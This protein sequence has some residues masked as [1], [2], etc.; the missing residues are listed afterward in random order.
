VT[1][2]ADDA[3]DIEARQARHLNIQYQDVRLM[4]F[5]GAQCFDTIFRFGAYQEIRPEPCERFREF[6]AQQRLVLGD[7]GPVL[8]LHGFSLAIHEPHAK[9]AVGKIDRD[10]QMANMQSSPL[11][12]DMRKATLEGSV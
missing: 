8:L 10:G 9:A 2:V 6:S 4:L 12:A 11:R 3:R 1:F 5:D 7:D